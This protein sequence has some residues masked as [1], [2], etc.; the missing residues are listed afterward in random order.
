[1]GLDPLGLDSDSDWWGGA[2]GHLASTAVSFGKGVGNAVAGAVVGVVEAAI[3]VGN[4]TR[5][6]LQAVVELEATHAFNVWMGNE[7]ILEAAG[8]VVSDVASAVWGQTG[9]RGMAMATHLAKQTCNA[10]LRGDAEAGGELV[11]GLVLLL[12]GGRLGKG[13][14]ARSGAEASGGL[15]EQ[16]LTANATSAELT[17]VQAEVKATSWLA[18]RV[19]RWDI[20]PSLKD[21]FVA[22]Y[23]SISLKSRTPNKG[24]LAEELQHAIDRAM[25]IFP[26]EF[27]ALAKTM[28]TN[29]G[30]VAKWHEGL[31]RRIADQ[32]EAESN[33]IFNRFL[34][35]DDAPAFRAAAK[36]AAAQAEIY[37]AQ[38]R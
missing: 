30:A 6:T 13:G 20:S 37:E 19:K 34:T 26:R 32:V 2:L 24:V 11:T 9:G 23:D 5:N 8:G 36:D 27:D 16:H 17:A 25:E 15:I 18:N 10:F 38:V 35:K 22:E 33:A 3:E 12:V 29:N 14:P 1:M 7:S 31:F 28:K 4:G 21:E